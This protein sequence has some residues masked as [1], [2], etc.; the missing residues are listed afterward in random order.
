MFR[1]LAWLS[2]GK[3]NYFVSKIVVL[4]LAASLGS[5]L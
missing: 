3:L 5:E 1:G 2:L 4:N